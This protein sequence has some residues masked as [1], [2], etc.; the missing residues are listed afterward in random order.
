MSV[1]RG[2]VVLSETGLAMLLP[3]LDSVVITLTQGEG[4]PPKSTSA[5][6][7]PGRCRAPGCPQW[8]P[9]EAPVPPAQGRS[10]YIHLKGS[11]ATL[12]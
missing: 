5:L 11:Q 12:E 1:V 3:R 6:Q 4:R 8:V 10:L 9:L 7:G 2:S